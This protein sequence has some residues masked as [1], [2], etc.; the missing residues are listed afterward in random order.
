MMTRMFA[1]AGFVGA[2]AALALVSSVSAQT[3]PA[4]YPA[5]YGDVIAKARQEG[6]VAVYTS[7]DLDQ[8]K[9][10]MDAFRAAYPGIQ[11]DWQDLGT[12]G[13][14]NRVI[15]EAAARQVGA[16]V[17]WSSA[18]D[19]QLTL[20]DKSYAESYASPEA[21]KLP[22]WA[23]YK[24]AAYATSIEPAAI[25]YNKTLLPAADVPQTRTDLIRILNERKDSLKGKVGTFDPE[26][27]G[28]GFLWFTNDVRNRPDT[29]DLIKALGG[30][31]GKLYSGSGQL[32]EKV[33]SGEHVL[34]FNVIGSYAL[35]W[36]KAN[37][38]LGV[39]FQ[40]DYTAA[41]SRVAI[42]T[43]NAPHPNAARLFLD[44][45][46]SEKGQNAS[47]ASGLPSVRTDVTAGM[48]ATT[49]N[50]RVGGKLMP[51]AL[52]E[53]TTEYLDQKRRAE[54]FQQWKRSL[55]N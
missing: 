32:R 8:A 5:G 2:A 21:G 6:K 55:A 12:N 49:L 24:N 44:F 37:P 19:L 16:D 26:K 9:G 42:I 53:T 46:L 3:V 7:T 35:E 28:T 33:V 47:A 50:E 20:V 48:N 41:F 10:L 51:I 13:T 29:W 14:Y 22:D 4:G 25:V 40:K 31:Q 38:N 54:F 39:V 23:K 36:A 1:R 34:L 43:K 17:V 45:M 18:M 30:V 11:I 27:S 15:S 52:N